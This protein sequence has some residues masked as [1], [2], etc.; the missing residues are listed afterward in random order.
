MSNTK[1]ELLKMTPVEAMKKF[2]PAKVPANFNNGR[3]DRNGIDRSIYTD[4]C[5]H[6]RDERAMRRWK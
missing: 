6:I 3:F 2:G 1:R 5:D 4:C